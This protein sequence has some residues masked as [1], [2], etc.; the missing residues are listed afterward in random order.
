MSI[1]KREGT[2]L[3]VEDNEG[4]PKKKRKILNLQTINDKCPVM[5][6]NEMKP[7]VVYEFSDSGPSHAKIFRTTVIFNNQTFMAEGRTKK[8][9]KKIV[10]KLILKSA[11]QLKEPSIANR[12]S[13]TDNQQMLDFSSDP[14]EVVESSPNFYCFESTH[15]TTGLLQPKSKS[16]VLNAQ[17]SPLYFLKRLRPGIKVEITK[18]E[19]NPH[20][21]KFT[22]QGKDFFFFLNSERYN[23]ILGIFTI[24]LNWMEKFVKGLELTRNRPKMLLHKKL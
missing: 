19:G 9:A 7:D 15:E 16:P 18:T 4:P 13:L 5:A 8:E 1:N 17:S 3:T 21:R 11:I 20:A 10:A 23:F 2:V 22:A 6:L 12:F 24:Q 14:S